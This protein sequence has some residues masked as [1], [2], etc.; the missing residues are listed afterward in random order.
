[1]AV[2]VIQ[3]TALVFMKPRV[4][5]WRYQRGIGLLKKI[6]KMPG[7]RSLDINLGS[8]NHSTTEVE[9]LSCLI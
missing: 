9:V 4:A 5:S 3:R 6:C 1:M 7:L 8:S 2:K